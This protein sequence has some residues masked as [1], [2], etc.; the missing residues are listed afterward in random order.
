MEIFS[1]A[2]YAGCLSV[3]VCGS[4]N[5]VGLCCRFQ[6]VQKQ[7][8]WQAR[9]EIIYKKKHHLSGMSS[10]VITIIIR[11][12]A[13]PLLR[14]AAYPSSCASRVL[15]IVLSWHCLQVWSA[16]YHH[17]TETWSSTA[18]DGCVKRLNKAKD[19][20]VRR[21]IKAKRSNDVAGVSHFAC[22]P[23]V[24]G[25]LLARRARFE[26]FADLSGPDPQDGSRIQIYVR[27]EQGT[28]KMTHEPS[29]CVKRHRS[30]WR[31]T[32]RWY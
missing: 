22:P 10:A 5:E 1:R 29:W 20:S 18:R 2:L 6:K 11:C 25:L 15:T 23:G 4:Q 9:D 24:P 14:R 28:Q 19:G 7:K 17:F 27:Y 31:P 8:G 32:V 26:V 16:R 13:L 3:G 21:F 12:F 30:S